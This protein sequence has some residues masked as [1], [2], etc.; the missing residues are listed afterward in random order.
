MNKKGL[1]LVFITAIISG[2]SIFINKYGVGGVNPYL[3]AF[4]KNVM[5][6]LAFSGFVLLAKE[7]RQ[8]AKLT[9][10]Q[11]LMLLVIG[12]VGGGAAFLLFFKGLSITSAAQGS[13]IH[14]TM[15]IYTMILASIFLREKIRKEMLIGALMIL[16][17]N[18]IALKALHLSFNRGDFYVFLATLLWAVESVISKYALAGLSPKI[19]AWGR[20]FFGAILILIFLAGSGQL[21]IISQL[22][23]EQVFWIQIASFILFGYVITWYSGLRHIP[24]STAAAILLLGSP[25]T[26]LLAFASTGKINFG[27]IVSSGLIT[28]GLIMILGYRFILEKIKLLGEKINVRA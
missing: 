6:A 11:W 12:F 23:F 18:L 25:I 4:L 1:L 15:F 22:N 10:K 8:L 17:G 2:F 27:E 20:M 13:F 21:T 5:V 24:V 28:G 7:W 9:K 26:T 19:V 3:F 14:K 16:A